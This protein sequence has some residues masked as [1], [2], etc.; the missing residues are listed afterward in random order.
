MDTTELTQY[1]RDLTGVQST[2]LVSDT[3]I[4]RWLN[5]SYNEVAQ[6]RTWDWMESTY[7]APLPAWTDHDPSLNFGYHAFTLPNG[8]RRILS[9]YLV[10]DNGAVTELIQTSDIDHVEVDDPKVKY[11]VLYE[12]SVRIVPKQDD[13][14]SVKFRY[15]Q[16][17]V[18]LL[19]GDYPAFAEQFHAILAYRT[20]VKLLDFMSDD[21][22]RSEKYSIEY[23]R[24]LNQMV[25]FYELD[26]DYRTFQLGQDGVDTRKYF[27]WFRPE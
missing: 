21:T 26:H 12:G 22:Q 6:E 7:R 10:N 25:G 19:E 5:E 9:A 27:P 8:S 3:L 16:A 24:L 15:T 2:D 17:W 13:N 4:L 11:D 1:V 23:Q 14:Y 18:S 20:A